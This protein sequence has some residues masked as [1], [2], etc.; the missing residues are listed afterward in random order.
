MKPRKSKKR[1]LSRRTGSLGTP[2]P[3][4]WQSWLTT[5]LSAL[6][7]APHMIPCEGHAEL[8]LAASVIVL[9][10][11]LAGAWFAHQCTLDRP[12]LHV[13]W[14]DAGMFVLV[15][16]SLASAL[17]TIQSGQGVPRPAINLAAQ[18]ISLLAM[19]WLARQLLH[20]PT[21]ARAICAVM[22][23]LGLAMSIHGIYQVTYSFPR[24]ILAFEANPDATLGAA[25]LTAPAG[26]P[27]RELFA[28]RLFS[29]DATSSFALANSLGGFLA[30]WL[31]ILTWVCLSPGSLQWTKKNRG[32]CAVLVGV[33][34]IVGLFL[35]GS[36]TGQLAA[37]IGCGLTA[38][39]CRKLRQG[40]VGQNQRDR[41]DVVADDPPGRER[42][43][44]NALLANG[45][46]W[47]VACLVLVGIM[48]WGLTSFWPMSG[49]AKSL[50][51]RW[52]YWQA[53]SSLIRDHPL[54]G[55]GLG[56][57]QN[58]YA[59]YKLPWSS[60]M[61][62]DP[63]NFAIE[64]WATAGAPALVA[65]IWALLLVLRAAAQSTALD[66]TVLDPESAP[67][68]A[69][70]LELSSPAASH[71]EIWYGGAAGVLVGTFAGWL[72]GYPVDLFFLAAGLPLFLLTWSLTDSWVRHGG[73]STTALT[74][75]LLA[76]CLNLSLAGGINYLSVA[77]TFWLLAALIVNGSPAGSVVLSGVAAR[78][79]VWVG[80]LVT[81]ACLF[82]VYRWAYAPVVYGR[83]H[84]HRGSALLEEAIYLASH[85]AP[86]QV[87][88]RLHGAAQEFELAAALDPYDPKAKMQLAQTR[89][90]LQLRR[91]ETLMSGLF[92]ETLEQA[93][94]QQSQRYVAWSEAARWYRRGYRQASEQA[95]EQAMLDSTIECWRKAVER[96]PN[97]AM[98]HAELAWA[99]RLADNGPAAQQEATRA[100]ELNQQNPHQEYKLERA[101]LSDPG[102]IGEHGNAQPEGPE[103]ESAHTWMERIRGA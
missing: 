77:T 35:T 6:I 26:S 101:R 32:A 34:L 76:L 58:V 59:A 97:S 28:N 63:H 67:E 2:S 66:S 103:S 44:P 16:W 93:L 33:P 42:F 27:Q 73:Y 70:E 5:G 74:I 102:P 62:A 48:I 72:V 88:A 82:G 98:L 54:W 12:R 25:G 46:K 79:A 38:G 1:N 29:G 50:V 61:V 40:S 43:Q 4:A 21:D 52:E 10:L 11:V 99:L 85:G 45:L 24:A 23:A 51:Y 56:Q 19:Y 91:G 87:G 90:E 86:D 71:L 69:L 3:Q 57:F 13:G 80:T 8:G 64:L 75:G 55:C 37:L 81:L 17:W 89:L 92:A 60:E 49:A 30:T 100:L 39:L 84:S 68:S 31:V 14:V 41:E 18:W 47:L 96:Y 94:S 65:L 15:M 36:R 53:T 22:L 9:W 95:S 78:R 83:A 20:R 7:V